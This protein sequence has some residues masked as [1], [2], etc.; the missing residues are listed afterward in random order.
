MCHRKGDLEKKSENQG[1]WKIIL[2]W[3]YLRKALNEVFAETS[4]KRP[5]MVELHKMKTV[6]E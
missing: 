6:E 5:R 1:I 3:Q 4:V 2:R